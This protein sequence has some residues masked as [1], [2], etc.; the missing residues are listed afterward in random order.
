[1]KKRITSINPKLFSYLSKPAIYYY[2]LN[3]KKIQ[4][5]PLYYYLA[6]GGCH[7]SLSKVL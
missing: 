3:L 5:D 1:M 7:L 6:A 2:A 4:I